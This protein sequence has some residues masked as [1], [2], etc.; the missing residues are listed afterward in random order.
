MAV[1]R[2]LLIQTFLA[3]SQEQLELLEPMLLELEQHPDDELGLA[4][5]F[6]LAHTL[7]GN[8]AVVGHEVMADFLHR[9]EGVLSRVRERTLLP[10]EEV[11]GL[12]LEALDALRR[13]APAAV[14]PPTAPPADVRA[15]TERLVRMAENGSAPSAA[16]EA[17]ASTAPAEG[18]VA[19]PRR[20]L[21][22]DIASLDQLLTLTGELAVARGR[23]AAVLADPSPAAARLAREQHQEADR[24]L[25]ELQELAMKLRLV[26]LG[27]TLRTQARTL[28]D[29]AAHGG[30]EARLVLEGEAVELDTSLVECL[31]D[32]L[33]HLVRNAVA[34]GLEAP[35]RRRA[36]GKPL[37][38]TVRV[39]AQQEAQVVV[40]TVQD[41]GGGLDLGR[42]AA[43][44]RQR[45]LADPDQLSPERLQQLIFEPGFSTAT[46]VT[47]VAGRGVG[48][49]VVR[50]NVEAMRG[51]V[52]VS[53]VA[54]AGAT[55]TLRLPLSLA[56]IQ[57]FAVSV[58]E[59]EFVVPMDDVVECIELGGERAE[60]QRG[61][62]NLRGEALPWVELRRLFG[63]APLTS[64]RRGAVVVRHPRGRA[65]LVVDRLQGE[66]QTVFKPLG[67]LL[68]GIPSVTGT[69]ILGNG[70]VALVLDV[71]G[72]L[73][74]VLPHATERSPHP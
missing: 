68:G 70:R 67:K 30:R 12:L 24:L 21:R 16:P 26:P 4:G 37:E 13:L 28:R 46:E 73:E 27:P 7:K 58:G 35:E 40:I 72:L 66:I 20:T 53:S 2:D 42:I 32:P 1:D 23:L 19:A 54:G 39:T 41:D 55:F 29:A 5:I 10:T 47:E 43:I 50:R 63:L 48:L 61:V 44:A 3:E 64:K 52:T 25:L 71:G 60:D 56:I 36:A 15:L 51:T 11:T 14:E 6:R 62:F 49:D 9:V 57:G 38:G 33:T 69:T 18:L 17:P 34:H 59:D 65:A 31:K 74:R 22:V 8:A 45:G